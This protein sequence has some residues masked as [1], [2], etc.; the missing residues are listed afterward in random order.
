M[1][2]SL[3]NKRFLPL[4]VLSAALCSMTLAATPAGAQSADNGKPNH[5]VVGNSGDKALAGAGR[6]LIEPFTAAEL[7]DLVAPVALYPDDLLAIVLP[8]ATYPLQIVQAARFL[9]ELENDDS[10]KPDE[11]WDESVVALLNY[12]E[13][14]DLLNSDLEWT[15]QLGEAVINQEAEVIEAVETFRDRA[16]LAGN[17]QTDEHQ[18]VSNEDGVIEI[19][20]VDPEVIYVPYYEPERVVVYQPYPVYHY[21]PSAY[22]LYYYPYPVGHHFNSHYFWGITTAF[23]ISWYS[24][25]LNV[26][27][28]DY[29]SHPYYGHSYYRYSHYYHRPSRH[30]FGG[31]RFAGNPRHHGDRWRPNRGHGAR[32]SHRRPGFDHGG[33]DFIRTSGGSRL[34]RPGTFKPRPG[35]RGKIMKGINTRSHG[36][37]LRMKVRPAVRTTRDAGRSPARRDGAWKYNATPETAFVAQNRSSSGK[38]RRSNPNRVQVR[39]DLR[40]EPVVRN[41]S[42]GNRVIRAA[43]P[44]RTFSRPTRPANQGQ[45]VNRTDRSH[46]VRT[47]RPDSVVS[48]RSR[49]RGADAGARSSSRQARP[50]P[51]PRQAKPATRPP[52]SRAPQS[53]P[54]PAASKPSPPPRSDRGSSA[55]KSG[56]GKSH[57]GGGR[58]R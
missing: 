42:R 15:W 44:R 3:L 56:H 4:A 55:S 21:Y 6:E 8:A 20:P 52:Q 38:I 25:H 39:R 45:S 9:D 43:E 14:I 24:H 58:H 51:P 48:N 50:S 31:H 53:R 41:K 40:S 12:P 2:K 46:T 27:H 49:G 13:V 30:Y 37:D 29:Y 36:A 47:S 28:W 22:P 35:F 33:N 7:E 5:V 11:D 32:P 19:T 18:V 17:L 23:T 34:G 10:L 1:F 57:R 54:A 16:I 26:H